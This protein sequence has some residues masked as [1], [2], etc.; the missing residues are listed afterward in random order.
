MKSLFNTLAIGALSVIA[1]YSALTF[2]KSLSERKYTPAESIKTGIETPVCVASDSGQLNGKDGLDTVVF[3]PS[4]VM[5]IED[6]KD[7]GSWLLETK[8]FEGMTSA[9]YS[10]VDGAVADMNND[11][12]DDI[13]YALPSGVYILENKGNLVFNVKTAVDGAALGHTALTGIGVKV[14]DFN[15]DGWK[16]IEYTNSGKVMRFMSRADGS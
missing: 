10:H 16:D 2:G 1:V 14:R 7:K 13:V 15:K 11:S 12:L 3:S 6:G 5:V 9:Y 4:G 8:D